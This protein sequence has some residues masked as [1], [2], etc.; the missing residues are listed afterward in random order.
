MLVCGDREAANG[1][2][3]VRHRQK[4]DVGVEATEAFFARLKE[5]IRTR[6]R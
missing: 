2:V 5:E 4:G 6:A 3:S 1:T